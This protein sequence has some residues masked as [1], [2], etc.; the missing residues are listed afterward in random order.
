MLSHEAVGRL[1]KT[2][3]LNDTRG[4]IRGSR[5]KVDYQGEYFDQISIVHVLYL[6]RRI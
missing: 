5:R 3:V 1:C 6:P 2:D 4:R